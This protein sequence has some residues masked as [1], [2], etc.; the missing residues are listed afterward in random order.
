ME[1]SGK[2]IIKIPK[3]SK[4]DPQKNKQLKELFELE[5]DNNKNK[6]DNDKIKMNYNETVFFKPNNSMNIENGGYTGK[7]NKLGSEN[8]KDLSKLINNVISTTL[9][10]NEI[11]KKRD[12]NSSIKFNVNINNNYYN[13]NF[14]YVIPP[15]GKENSGNIDKNENQE[16]KGGVS[17]FFSKIVNY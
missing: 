9:T 4:E 13:S 3:L 2:K 7:F 6:K 10:N 14:N 17:N 1:S 15:N 8:E 16:T 11:I 12:T 5:E